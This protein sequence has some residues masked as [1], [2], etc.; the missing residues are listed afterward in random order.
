MEA[1]LLGV[2]ELTRA[3]E[4]VAVEADVAARDAVAKTAAMV[5]SAAKR[6]FVGSHSKGDPHVGGDQP[7][8]VTGTARRSIR[9]D[10]I[11]RYG[12]G[13]YGTVVAPRV[14]YGRRLELGYPGGGGGRG[15]QATRA[16][17]YFEEPAKKA[18]DEFPRIAATRWS[19]FLHA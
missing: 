13:D 4:R 5:E 18:R 1:R 19:A 14:I 2:R 16:F 12:L 11:R 17:P 3:L 6:N 9:T 15:H 8:V 7:N 10:P